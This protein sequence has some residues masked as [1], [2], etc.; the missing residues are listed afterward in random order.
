MDLRAP[1]FLAERKPVDEDDRRFARGPGVVIVDG[2]AL[3]G[4]MHKERRPL[5]LFFFW[6]TALD[7]FQREAFVGFLDGI[8][9]RTGNL[10][11]NGKDHRF[12]AVAILKFLAA[13]F[14]DL[15][16]TVLVVIPAKAGIQSNRV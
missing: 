14:T 8:G 13:I 12:D 11:V 16:H 3:V 5:R 15:T 4:E 1:H 6:I 9:D 2:I 7:V 10:A